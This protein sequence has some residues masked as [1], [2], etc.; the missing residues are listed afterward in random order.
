[1]IYLNGLYVEPHFQK[2]TRGFRIFHDCHYFREKFYYHPNNEI[3]E[4]WMR[5][6]MEH[7][8]CY[9]VTKKYERLNML[10]QGKF[11]T[12]YLCHHQEITVSGSDEMLAMKYI[13]KQSLTRKERE[14]LRDEI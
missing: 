8:A 13:E 12:V 5:N 11:S 9:D 10:G 1:V 4:K 6:L 3:S 2:G 7:A 14:F